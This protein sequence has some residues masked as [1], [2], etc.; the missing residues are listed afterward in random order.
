LVRV[1]HA[2]ARRRRF[3]RGR[4]FVGLTRREGESVDPQSLRGVRR[5]RAA[6]ADALDELLPAMVR[7]DPRA[8]IDPARPVPPEVSACR[9][10]ALRGRLPC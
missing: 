5:L 9:Y 6:S 8:G 3:R 1:P 2:V 4:P 7:L 10:C